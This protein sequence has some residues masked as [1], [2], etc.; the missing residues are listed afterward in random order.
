MRDEGNGRG[1][2]CMKEA[3]LYTVI[4]KFDQSFPTHFLF[5]LLKI[6]PHQEFQ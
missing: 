2:C 1:P 4:F 5:F 6:L 3:T